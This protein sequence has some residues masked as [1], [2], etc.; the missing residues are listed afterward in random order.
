[1]KAWDPEED[2]IIMQMHAAEGPKWKSIVKRL[3]GRTVIASERTGPLMF[4]TW[5]MCHMFA[6]LIG[7]QSVAAH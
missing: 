1:M 3:P 4:P 5:I 2:H 7:P 6:G